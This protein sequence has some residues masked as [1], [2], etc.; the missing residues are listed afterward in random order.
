MILVFTGDGKGKTSAAI[1]TILRSLNSKKD[2][3]LIQ[4]LKTGRSG[5]I[6]TLKKLQEISIEPF[7]LLTIRSFGKQDFTHPEKKT[8]EDRTIINKAQ[9]YISEQIDK[10]PF[11]LVLD[12]ILVALSFQLIQET[13]ILNLI[14]QCRDQKIHLLMTGRGVTQTIIQRSD[15]VTDMKKIKHP[16]DDGVQGLKGI[17]F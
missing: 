7:N 14:A 17:D 6:R 3:A 16:F 2:V 11:L 10:K 13:Y 4:V 1:G 8:L 12:E 9:K 15:L 5:E